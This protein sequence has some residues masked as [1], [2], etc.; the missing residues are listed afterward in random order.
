MSTKTAIGFS[1]GLDSTYVLW[2][3]LNSTDDEVTAV[4]FD[5][6]YVSDNKRSYQPDLSVYQ[7]KVTIDISNWLKINE[8]NFTLESRVVKNIS[9]DQSSL[10]YFIDDLAPSVVDGTFDRICFGVGPRWENY[11]DVVTTHSDGYTTRYNNR[12]TSKAYLNAMERNGASTTAFWTPIKEWNANIF[13][14]ITEL[15]PD[16][17]DLTYSCVVPSVDANGNFIS[18]GQCVKCHLRGIAEY[19]IAEGVLNETT[20]PTWLCEQTDISYVNSSGDSVSTSLNF[21]VGG[22]G[23][24]LNSFISTGGVWDSV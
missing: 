21:L 23:K 12:R 7:K 11:P 4:H 24:K 20:F 10:V 1:G 2:K 14:I 3:L 13:K 16:L 18:C 15:P 17:Y 19:K 5:Q 22:M 6:T 8:R 9:Q